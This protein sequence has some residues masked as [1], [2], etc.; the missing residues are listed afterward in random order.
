MTEYRP[1]EQVICL[2][3]F[4]IITT[5]N[6]IS[7]VPGRNSIAENP[8][9]EIAYNPWRCAACGSLRVS[10]QVWVDSNTHEVES[11][12]EDKDDLW[13]DECAEH[14]RQVRESELISDTIEPWWEHG[15]TMEA[16]EVITGLK[17]ED[18]SPQDDF[19]VFRNACNTWWRA[20]PNGEKI[21]HWR[22]AAAPKEK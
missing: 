17:R 14:T 9:G 19:R 11:V 22:Q 7:D 13:C 15:P 1:T 20:R 2:L 18:S 12:T 21:R 5:M 3:R 6:K 4:F 16:R 8:T 10:C